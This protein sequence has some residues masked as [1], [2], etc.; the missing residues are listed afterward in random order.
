MSV[1]NN[2]FI[3]RIQ[4]MKEIGSVKCLHFKLALNSKLKK[5]KIR[6]KLARSLSLP[7][8]SADWRSLIP[9]LYRVS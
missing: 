1:L 6:D 5:D 4:M 7:R 9:R 8:Y 2:S 3:A